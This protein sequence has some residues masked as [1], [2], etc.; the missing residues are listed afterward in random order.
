MVAHVRIER[1]DGIDIGVR[2]SHTR[3]GSD[4]RFCTR[5][6]LHVLRK[7]LVRLEQRFDIR[8]SLHLFDESFLFGGNTSIS[9]DVHGRRNPRLHV[10]R[11]ECSYSVAGTHSC[12]LVFIG[13]R[14]AQVDGV[15]SMTQGSRRMALRE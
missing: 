11:E 3:R 9:A 7:R 14:L 13:N 8:V 6:T 1:M 5:S 10:V 4:K 2:L 12:T 15:A